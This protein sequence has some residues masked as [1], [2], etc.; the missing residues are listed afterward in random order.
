MTRR[1]LGQVMAVMVSLCGLQSCGRHQ[2]D[3]I[4]QVTGAQVQEFFLALPGTAVLGEH[5]LV[6]NGYLKVGDRVTVVSPH[7]DPAAV[8][9]AG[10]DYSSIGVQA[11]TGD[12]LSVAS[13]DLRNN[14]VV[15]GDVTTSGSIVSE[16][17]AQVLGALQ[18]FAPPPGEMADG[19]ESSRHDHCRTR[20]RDRGGRQGS[21]RRDLRRG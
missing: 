15:K 5:A 18:P 21:A 4:A 13:L 11:T 2:S 19:E 20:G 1:T 3:E 6:A 14:A 17:N 8:A 7:G 12:V 10:S 16:Q 9:N